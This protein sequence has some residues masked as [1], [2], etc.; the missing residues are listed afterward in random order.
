MSQLAKLYVRGSLVNKTAKNLTPEQKSEVERL[1]EIAWDDPELDSAKIEFCSILRRTIGNEYADREFALAEIWITFW[2]TA[3]NVLFHAPARGATEEDDKKYQDWVA[4]KEAITTNPIARKKYFKTYLYQYMR[5]ILNENKIQMR[6][7]IKNISGLATDVAL[8]LIQ[9]YI[10]N[11]GAKKI[12]FNVDNNKIN[13]EVNLLPMKTM[14]KICTIRDEFVDYD[15]FVEIY[16]SYIVVNPGEDVKF[17]NKKLKDKER[18]KFNSMSGFA[19]DDSKNSFQQHCEFQAVNRMEV[20]V[21]N[22]LVQDQ[23][24]A[25]TERLTPE[26]V[27]VFELMVN[28]PKEFLDEFYPR[29]KKEVRPRETH[30]AQWLGISKNIVTKHVEIIRRQAT[31]LDIG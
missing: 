8:E 2:R 13:C 16:D 5:Q 29:R 15:A 26:T 20:D 9:F 4:R 3:V 23:I 19:D 18:A 14:K 31:A 27:K 12:D 10:K 25:L 30:I 24:N 21:D 28:P 1:M 22:M 17:I 7:V 6:Q 11:S